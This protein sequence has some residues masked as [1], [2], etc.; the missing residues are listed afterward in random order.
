[1][2]FG[3]NDLTDLLIQL[4]LDRGT[5]VEN[6]AERDAVDRGKETHCFVAQ[7]FEEELKKVQF[8]PELVRTLGPKLPEQ[9]R[10]MEGVTLG[11]ERFEIPE[12]LFRPNLVGKDTTGLA[13]SAIDCILQ[14]HVDLRPTL[15]ERI[16]LCGVC[17]FVFS[18]SY[19]PVQP[20]GF[21]SLR[22]SAIKFVPCSGI[23]RYLLGRIAI[24]WLG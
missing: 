5:T 9:A 6:P 23:K 13:T 20:K 18:V 16:I 17:A 10:R 19:F 24:P 1:M 15:C 2:P 22:S 8:N 14:C 12:A 11:K 7:N 4:L 3:G 21:T